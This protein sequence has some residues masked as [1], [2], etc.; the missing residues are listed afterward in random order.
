MNRNFTTALRPRA[1]AMTMA[2]LAFSATAF[3]ADIKVTL[4]GANEVPPV[5][6]SATGG[7]TVTVGADGAVSGGVTTTGV[8]GTAA[9]I[10]EAPAGKNGG[11]IVPMVKSGDSGWT[12]APGAK[13]TEAQ[14]ASL[15]AG[16]LYIN[17]HSAANPGGELRG[18]LKP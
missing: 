8:A 15:K 17:V 6:T 13:L 14:M 5:T 3:G 16:N 9:H 4:S 7:G 1:A 10:H 12:F 11:V 18:Q 2:L